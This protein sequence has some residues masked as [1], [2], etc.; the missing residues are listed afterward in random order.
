[1]DKVINIVKDGNYRIVKF[2]FV[3]ASSVF[4]QAVI[5]NVL[6][7]AF[8]I[9]AGIATIL[10]DHFAIFSSFFLNNKITFK[11][12]KIGFGKTMIS[13]FFKYYGIVM[14]STLI[15]VIIVLAG[16]E[17]FGKGIITA[18]VFFV[19]GLMVGFLWNYNVHRDVVWNSENN[20]GGV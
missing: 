2:I 7:I 17:I 1:M 12:K 13:K 6:I 10:A 18:N 15:Q 11:D 20:E 5:F 9:N 8:R 14:I 19:V 4:I 3:G 16:V